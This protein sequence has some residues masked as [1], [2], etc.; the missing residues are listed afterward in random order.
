MLHRFIVV[1][2]FGRDGI[3]R[4]TNSFCSIYV[5]YN[6]YY[7][8]ISTGVLYNLYYGDISTGIL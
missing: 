7:G 3:F 5:L 6:L 4:L 2:L 1:S 8:D